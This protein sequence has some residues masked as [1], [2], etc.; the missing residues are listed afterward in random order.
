MR[1]FCTPGSPLK[2]EDLVARLVEA[3]PALRDECVI[4]CVCMCVYV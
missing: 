1:L 2:A 3:F 4:V